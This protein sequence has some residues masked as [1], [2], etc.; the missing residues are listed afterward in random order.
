[1]PVLRGLKGYLYVVAETG[2]GKHN[3]RKY[4]QT[5]LH[6]SSIK[7]NLITMAINVVSAVRPYESIITVSISEIEARTENL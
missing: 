5:Q 4:D 2:P 7:K 3:H 1:M 6:F